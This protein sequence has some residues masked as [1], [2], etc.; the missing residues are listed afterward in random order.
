MDDLSEKKFID[1]YEEREWRFIKADITVIRDRKT[2]NMAGFL[3]AVFYKSKEGTRVNTL[4]KAF[5]ALKKEYRM[6]HE[7]Y[8]RIHLHKKYMNYFW[9]TYTLHPVKDAIKDILD[10]IR[11]ANFRNT[12][13]LKEFTRALLKEIR[14]K[15]TMNLVILAENPKTYGE[16]FHLG[17]KMETLLP[18]EK[19]L[20]RVREWQETELFKKS[21]DRWNKYAARKV[22][23]SKYIV[24]TKFY[25]NTTAGEWRSFFGKDD[26]YRKYYLWQNFGCPNSAIQVTIPIDVENIL[27]VLATALFNRVE[28]KV[29]SLF[30]K[31]K[32]GTS[33]LNLSVVPGYRK[34]VQESIR[35]ALIEIEKDNKKLPPPRKS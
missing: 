19:D 23:K 35:L 12:K 28:N 24:D 31:S 3:L 5:H 1:F 2:D 30:G 21:L 17:L 33:N 25:V 13:S 4:C 9:Q 29:A 32:D 14:A 10:R 8:H 11:I 18:T 22:I 6:K 7:E 26:V 20:D 34:T 15:G 27:V 16:L